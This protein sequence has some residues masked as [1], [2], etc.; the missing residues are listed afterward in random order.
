MGNNNLILALDQGTTS[1][2]AVAYDTGLRQIADASIPLQQ[3]FPEPS[4]VE[5]DPDQIFTAAVDV[6]RRTLQQV[7]PDIPAALGITN[8]RETCILWSKKTGQPIHNALVWQDRRTAPFCA[9]LRQSGAEPDVAE[10]TGL[11]LD[12]YFSAT[13]VRWLL[14]KLPDARK[15]AESGDLLFGTIDTWLIWKLTGG[16]VHATDATNASRTQ[17][18]N[19]HTGQWDDTLLA[20]FGVPRPIL[21]E[22]RDSQADYGLTD[23]GVVGA[24]IPIAGVAGDQQAAA[25]GQA[26]FAAGD[27]KATFGTGCF[28]L[29]NTA[30]RLVPSKNRL[31]T[32]I[33]A[34]IGGHRS[35]ALE[36]SVFMAGATVQWLRDHLGII[37]SAEET[38]S[39]AQSAD[40]DSHVHLVPAFQG[41]GAPQWDSEARGLICGLSR[42]SGRAEIVRAALE[43]VAWQTH[44][45]MTAITADMKGVGLD[46][47]EQ[48]RVDGGMARNGWFLQFLADILGRP[49][50]RGAQLEA[51]ALGAAGHAGLFAGLIE[52]EAALSALWKADQTFYPQMAAG[53]RMAR[54]NKWRDAI[55]RAA[56]APITGS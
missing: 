9:E 36:G 37:G 43:G 53:E 28:V 5:H 1:T 18:Y 16:R 45:L 54:H 26:C 30:D 23:K 35:Y 48:L 11:L 4:W 15:R 2:R 27:I 8:Q 7:A 46:S 21:P 47:P 42:K 40:P 41:L 29:V 52:D 17:L 32:T 19:I 10:R 25:Y 33:G 20:L 6:I 34:Q 22:I 39:L 50:I 13:K 49:V 51:T 55:A 44:D 14:D 31:L 24:Q 38:E 56:S 12:P 3:H